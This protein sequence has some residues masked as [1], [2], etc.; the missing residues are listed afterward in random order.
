MADF[1][2][3]ARIS[4]VPLN[5]ALEVQLAGRKIVICELEGKFF[6]LDAVC[7]HKGGPLGACPPENGVLFCPLHGWGFDVRSGACLTR[8]DKWAESFPVRVVGDEI[9]IRLE[10]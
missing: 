6:A 1:I 9:Q 7:P 8:P 4:Q 3:A 2:T 5:G 10:S